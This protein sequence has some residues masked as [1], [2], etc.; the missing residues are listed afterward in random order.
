MKRSHRIFLTYASADSSFAE[1]LSGELHKL[2]NGIRTVAI[3]DAGPIDKVF[4]LIKQSL[5]NSDLV[6]FIVPSQEGE[7]QWALAALG[8]AKVLGKSILAVMPDR[9]RYPNSVYLRTLL[10]RPVLDASNMVMPLLAQRVLASVATK[11]A[12]A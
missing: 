9:V 7:G 8:A 2:D 6:V 12:A 5:I 1:T 10:D 11:Y 3:A 4:G